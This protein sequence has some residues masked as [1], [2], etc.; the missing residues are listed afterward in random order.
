MK[1]INKVKIITAALVSFLII[2]FSNPLLALDKSQS[3]IEFK[4]VGRVNQSPQFQF[5]A[6]NTEAGEYLVKVKDADGNVLYSETLKGINV[7]RNYRI[8]M[9]DADIAEAFNLRFEVTNL[10]SKETY[11]YNASRNTRVVED[12][13]VAK[14]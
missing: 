8:D 4:L 3:P 13:I 7:W 9:S 1:A 14:L 11:I 12:I 5:K 2:G 6:N 10:R